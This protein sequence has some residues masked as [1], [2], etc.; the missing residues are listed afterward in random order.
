LSCAKKIL[1]H[2]NFILTETLQVE[3]ARF[4]TPDKSNDVSSVDED[5]RYRCAL[6]RGSRP[7]KSVKQQ[8]LADTIVCVLG[9]TG[10]R[11]MEGL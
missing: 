11:R 6:S 3:P 10:G 5:A 1:I 4:K 7:S 9:D 2:L 8:A